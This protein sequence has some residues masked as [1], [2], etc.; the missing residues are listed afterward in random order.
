VAAA[1][2]TKR[3]LDDMLGGGSAVMLPDVQQLQQLEIDPPPL[4][5]HVP[6]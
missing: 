1:A 4:L 3:V 5:Q 6:K 2:E